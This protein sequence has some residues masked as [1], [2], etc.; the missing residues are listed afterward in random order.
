MTRSRSRRVSATSRPED[1]GRA[2]ARGTQAR[3]RDPDA[4]RRARHR[5]PGPASAPTSSSR[6]T[7]SANA[8]CACSP[9]KG[10]SSSG[11]AAPAR[12]SP[13][14]TA[15]MDTSATTGRPSLDGIAIASGFVPV[16][17]GPP[18]GC[19]RRRG[20]RRGQRR[21][22]TAFGETAHPVP[23]DARREAA[24]RDDH[25]RARRGAR[26]HRAHDLR[27]AR[28]SRARRCRP[29]ARTRPRR[30]SRRGRA[31]GSIVEG[32]EP[33]HTG[34]P[35]PV[36]SAAVGVREVREQDL[37]GVASS[38]RRRETLACLVRR[39]DPGKAFARKRRTGQPRSSAILRSARSGFTTTASRRPRGTGG[40]S[41]SRSTRSTSR[42]RSPRPP[43]AR[44]ARPPSRG[45]TAA[46]GDVPCRHR[47]R[48]QPCEP[49]PPAKPSSLASASTISWSAA[50]TMND[51]L[52]AA[53]VVRGC[54]ERVLVHVLAERRLER[55]GDDLPHDIDGQA[56]QDRH[57]AVGRLTDARW[58]APKRANTSCADRRLGEIAPPD[59][60]T[61]A[62]LR[63]ERERARLE[64]SVRSRSK[65]AAPGT[66]RASRG[67]SA[68]CG[69]SRRATRRPTSRAQRSPVPPPSR[70]RPRAPGS[71]RPPTRAARGRAGSG[72]AA[73]RRSRPRAP[74]RRRSRRAPGPVPT[75]YDM[76][77]TAPM[78]R[79]PVFTRHLRRAHGDLLRRRLRRR[80]DER[81][82]TREELAERHRDVARPRRHVHE[83]RVELAPVDVGEELLERLV[84]H[85]PAPHDRC[86]L[87]EEEPDRHE[88]EVAANG[89]HDHLV[90]GD[91]L[92]V[93]AEHVRDRVAVHV[94]VEDTDL[95][96]ER[97]QRVR[98][99]RRQRRL[100]DSALPGRDRDHARRGRER[101]LASARGRRAGASRA[102][103]SRP[104]SSRRSRA[105]P[106]SRPAPRRRTVRPDPRTTAGADS[107]RP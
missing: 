37:D 101:D 27:R 41:R 102:R 44:R 75:R 91:R 19:G 68:A 21:H 13:C 106:T 71:P 16:S 43:R 62:E 38:P 99:V 1:A 5:A 90:D 48:P 57:R 15:P 2:R 6:P 40:R 60:P 14:V 96:A 39:H 74:G 9:P 81:L 100:A 30:A 54:V 93:H 22:E 49:I 80:H 86:V 61:P 72:R 64:T 17:G 76:F 79:I 25:A 98:E 42:G 26:E 107:L 46:E 105:G 66:R 11:R 3:G 35:M 55:L 83:Q 45:R 94:A 31:A 12:T 59:Q 53:R 95:L 77:S 8:L 52:T 10:T 85:R 82:G 67:A 58:P 28:G 89:R 50:E 88:L 29:S 92:L 78:T 24:A 69:S 20:R 51:A 56:P 23:E 63:G 73:G 47:P 36:L 87:L 70:A 103:P 7:A 4:R 65:N 97:G 32:L 84:Q 34:Q 18:S 104:A 33:G